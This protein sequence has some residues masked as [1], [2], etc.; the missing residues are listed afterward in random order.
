MSD[1]HN[2]SLR[3]IIVNN[4]LLAIAILALFLAIILTLIAKDILQD[5]IFMPLA[6]LFWIGKLIFESFDQRAIWIAFLIVS[7]VSAVIFTYPI[8]QVRLRH[9]E[10]T[11]DNKN[12]IMLWKERLEA[13][14]RGEYL[15]WR[16][17]QHLGTMIAD[18]IAYQEGFTR[19]QIILRL[20]SGKLNLPPDI[21]AYLLA[22]H[23]AHSFTDQLS[24]QLVSLT[25]STRTAL[26]L[27]PERIAGI[28]EAYLGFNS[29]LLDPMDHENTLDD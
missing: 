13:T 24:D 8:F 18:T 15:K 25:G 1:S 20:L 29:M 16:L 17:A 14:D 11:L 19:D 10:T 21:Q 23:K 28:I 27:E 5:F 3:D 4:R 7:T 22:A 26:D 2:K 9:K 12:R 6:Y